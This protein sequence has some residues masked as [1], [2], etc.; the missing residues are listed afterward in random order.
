MNIDDII[1]RAGG[2]HRVADACHIGIYGVL[3]WSRKNAIPEMRRPVVAQLAGVKPE[4]LARWLANLD[5][6][7]RR[8][9]KKRN[10][11]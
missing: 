8:A 5:P 2:L 10:G 3:Q 11:K 7:V 1:A 6:P 4:T 9:Y